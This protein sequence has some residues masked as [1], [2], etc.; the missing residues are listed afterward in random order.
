MTIALAKVENVEGYGI[1]ELDKDMK[2]K[3]FIE[4]PPADKAPS[5]YANAGIY[6]LSPE[7]RKIVE[8][9]QVKSIMKERNRLDFGFDLI[10][11]L[12]EKG[13]PVYGHELKIWYD[14]GTPENYLKA[15]HDALHGKLKIRIQGE[16]ILPDKNVW[17]QGYSEES[18]K[19]REE[20]IKKYKENKL[21]IEGAALIG[22]HSRIGDYSKISDSNIDNFCIL[23][24]NVNIER[25]AIMDAAK[26]GD[27]THISDSI[28]GRKVV[29]QSARETPTVIESTSVIGDDVCI[30][31]GC[32][33]IRT[34][35][36]PGLTIPHRMT[37]ID[38]FLQNYED[39]VQL[40]TL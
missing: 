32:K 33:I 11:Y 17:V 14:V 19:R 10:P 18:I 8:S 34:K 3:R 38:R 29:V 25:S 40:A 5:N 9:A 26:I 36:N 13:F 30:K 4:K 37:Y 27:Y 15:M 2:I 7:V 20:I 16:R 39:V 28:L 24:E 12:V 6:L 21:S 22:R 31:E 1:A 35:I 23:G